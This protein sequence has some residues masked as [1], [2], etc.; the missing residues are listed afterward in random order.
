[1]EFDSDTE[2]LIS[3]EGDFSVSNFETESEIDNDLDSVRYWVQIDISANEPAPPR[4]KF[5]RNS[6][7]TKTIESDDPL[8]YFQQFFNENIFS[9]I[10]SE[11]NKYAETYLSNKELT[12]S[13]RLLNKYETNCREINSFMG[14]LLLQG[15][16]KKT[17]RKVILVKETYS[18][19]SF[20][21]TSD[22]RK[23]ILFADKVFAF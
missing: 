8:E 11:T 13:S 4:F 10:V 15:L 21:R 18:K 19:H 12:P 16:V 17:C 14:L 22:G 6:G 1:M 23:E 7:L 3:S 5:T 2:S 9:F 20:F